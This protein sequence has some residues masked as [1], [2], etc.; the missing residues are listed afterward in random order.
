MRD[1]IEIL[2]NDEDVKKLMQEAAERQK[3]TEEEWESFKKD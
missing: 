3:L 2:N 1:I